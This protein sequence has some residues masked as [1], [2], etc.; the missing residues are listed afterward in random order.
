ME[1]VPI[2]RPMRVLG[3]ITIGPSSSKELVGDLRGTPRANPVSLSAWEEVAGP[4]GE[5][6]KEGDAVLAVLRTG[7]EDVQLRL[8]AAMEGLLLPLLGRTVAV[9]RT[10]SPGSQSFTVREVKG[11]G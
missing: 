5:V 9:L 3:W 1:I 8:P 6:R 7:S 4:L 10:D 2:T 11:H